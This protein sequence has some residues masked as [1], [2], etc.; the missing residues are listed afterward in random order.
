MDSL[1]RTPDVITFDYQFAPNAQ[2]ARNLLNVAGIPYSCCEQPFVLPRPILTDLG[3]TYRRVPVNAIGKDIYC[4]NR[5]FLEAVQKIFKDKA[6]P[7]SPADH[8]YESFGYRTFWTC[9]QLVPLELMSKQLAEDRKKLFAVLTRDDYGDIRQ[10]ALGELKQWLDI[11]EYDFLSHGQQFIA[12]DKP[13]AADVHAIWMLKWA[14]ET[15]GCGKEP[16]FAKEDFPKAYKW[17]EGFPN[18]T[19]EN[20][21]PKLDAKDAHQKVL[22][23]EYAAEDIGVDPKDPTGLKKGAT[24]VVETNDDASPGN[25]PQHGKLVGLNHREI[26]VELDNGIR[27]HFPRIGYRLREA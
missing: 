20:D 27:V 2:K 18:H 4:D 10:S 24:V 1:S 5:P 19:P 12:G 26:V 15:V 6:L 7:T 17:F 25:A 22:D 8:A 21:A 23:A 3:I 11:V 9:L 13:G 16:G 14:I